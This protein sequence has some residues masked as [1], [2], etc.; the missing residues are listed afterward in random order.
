MVSVKRKS[1][2][3]PLKNKKRNLV[4]ASAGSGFLSGVLAVYFLTF[5][6]NFVI[7]LY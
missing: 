1:P 6:F 7:K 5:R 3:S 4:A 2:G